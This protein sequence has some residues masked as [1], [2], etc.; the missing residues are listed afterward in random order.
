MTNNSE[1]RKPDTTAP[2]PHNTAYHTSR[3]VAHLDRADLDL[4]RAAQH[5]PDYIV[6]SAVFARHELKRCRERIANIVK[7]L[8]G[9]R[10]V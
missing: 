4:E 9:R 5:A 7:L 2:E 1:E 3:A 6:G 8:T 10:D